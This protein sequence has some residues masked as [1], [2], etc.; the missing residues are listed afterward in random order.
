[1]KIM[2]NSS[3]LNDFIKKS[4]FVK[5]EGIQIRSVDGKI[6]LVNCD[7]ES[8]VM[9]NVMGDVYEDG[10]LLI[11]KEVYP[12]I[13]DNQPIIITDDY[14]EVGSRKIKCDLKD[15]DYPIIE[16]DFIFK[17]FDLSDKELKTLLEVE[18]AISH[19]ITKP[20]LNGIRI[21]KNKFIAIDGYR[22]CER[23]G[24]FR[25]EIQVVISNYKM[26]K[27]LRGQIKATCNNRY[28]NYQV[29]D[30]NYSNRLLEGEF[31]EIDKL[32]PRDNN[33]LIQIDKNEL[34]EILK[35]MEKV[36]NKTKNSLVKLSIRNNTLHIK[37]SN[38]SV[39][40]EDS[41]KCDSKGDNLDI[42]FNCKYLLEAVKDMHKII[43]MKFTT[44]VNPAILESPGKYEMILPVRVSSD[45]ERR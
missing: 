22:M 44:N 12:L 8:Q 20:I 26:L 14:V 11:P 36:S 5:S 4:K 13:K 25:T 38:K 7:L 21:E 10:S 6:Q 42:A 28:I 1:M 39:S 30:Y 16:G 27:G 32:K 2:F 3:L 43:S 15:E 19:D 45:I 41:M 29:G 33:T 40:V 24:D 35:S 31:I 18:H 37:A 17:V 34:E 9:T 23:I